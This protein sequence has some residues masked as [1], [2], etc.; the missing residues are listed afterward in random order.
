MAEEMKQNE[1][2]DE[3]VENEEV[4]EAH[5]QE[6][7]EQQSIASVDASSKSTKQ[8]SAP[9]TKAKMI[10]AMS[11]KMF[12]M[13]KEQLNAAYSKMMEGA[14]FEEAE[15]VEDADTVEAL[16][17][18]MANEAT[19]S[20]EFKEKTSLIFEAALRSKL[21]EEVDRL[22]ESYS[23]ELAEEVAATKEDMVDKVDSYLNYVVESWMEDNKL[24]V[25]AGIRTEIAE[26]FMENLKQVFVESY[27]EVPESKIDLVDELSEQVEELKSKLNESIEDSMSLAE[28]VKVMKRNQ[29]IAEASSDLADSQAEKLAGLMEGVAFEDA[30]SFAGKV[31]TIKESFFGEKEVIESETVLAEAVEAEVADEEV[32]LN[33]SMQAYL[34]ALKK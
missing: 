15:L 9:K 11:T 31:A 10:A 33:A 2:H 13:N 1:L 34:K 6:N 24:A 18:A 27:I 28:Q 32:E 22:E 14:E 23:Q 7:A 30:E 16:D 20:E 3:I 12:G 25:E 8:A 5:D 26:N 4:M 19:L 21:S 17:A 29:V